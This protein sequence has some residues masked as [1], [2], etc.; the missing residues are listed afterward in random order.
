MGILEYLQRFI[1]DHDGVRY[2][3][4]QLLLHPLSEGGMYLVIVARCLGRSW[5]ILQSLSS[6]F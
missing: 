5:F 6:A 2:M 3:F 4:G 1:D